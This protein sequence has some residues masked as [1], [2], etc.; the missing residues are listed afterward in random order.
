MCV[1]SV[2]QSTLNLHVRHN[3]G[4]LGKHYSDF[5]VDFKS[6][7]DDKYIRIKLYIYIYIYIFVHI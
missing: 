3:V 6:I 7:K 2:W 5:Y 4:L 1:T